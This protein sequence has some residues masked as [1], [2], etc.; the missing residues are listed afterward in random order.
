MEEFRS[1]SF[2]KNTALLEATME[3]E[4][5]VKALCCTPGEDDTEFEV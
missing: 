2:S 4:L 5:D 1:L 3:Q